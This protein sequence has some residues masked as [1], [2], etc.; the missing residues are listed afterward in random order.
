M[1]ALRRKLRKGKSSDPRAK[2]DKWIAKEGRDLKRAGRRV[3]KWVKK[4]GKKIVKEGEKIVG[5]IS[6]IGS[7]FFSTIKTAALVVGA[8]AAGWGIYKLSK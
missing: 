7:G 4:T 5:G 8:G 6:G 3:K 2:F 1:A